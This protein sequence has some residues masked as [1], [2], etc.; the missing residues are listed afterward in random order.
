[1]HSVAMR[2]PLLTAYDISSI[3]NLIGTRRGGPQAA[4]SKS[5][6]AKPFVGDIGAWNG[7]AA[8]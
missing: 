7:S 6:S 1:M 2:N 4:H 8:T 5:S 3:L